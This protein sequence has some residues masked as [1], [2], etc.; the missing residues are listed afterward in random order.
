MSIQ[1]PPPPPTLTVSVDPQGQ[2]DAEGN[3]HV[4]GTFTCAN[5][6]FLYGQIEVTQLWERLKISGYAQLLARGMC[7]GQPHPW[8]RVVAS[9]TGVY[10]AG[11]A[12][13]EI[14][15]RAYGELTYA[16]S[17]TTTDITLTGPGQP[18]GGTAAAAPRP[19]IKA[20]CSASDAKTMW[21]LS[22]CQR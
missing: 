5:A 15:A 13:V 10:G 22:A 1:P 8:E 16:K 20:P 17:D 4:S 18:S 6:A 11:A 12:T 7:D 9:E 14:D 3:A 2:A 21:Q 19:A